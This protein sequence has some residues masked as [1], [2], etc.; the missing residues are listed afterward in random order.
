MSML[1]LAQTVA[2]AH[3]MRAAGSLVVPIAVVAAIVVGLVKRAT[4]KPARPAPPPPQYYGPAPCGGA[5]WTPPGWPTQP[6]MAPGPGRPAQPPPWP[7][8]HQPPAGHR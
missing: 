7:P 4:R 2:D 5:A 1:Y 3:P 8:Q 6:P